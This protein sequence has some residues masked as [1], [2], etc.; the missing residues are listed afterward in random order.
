MESYD[1]A[2]QATDDYII[3][4]M[5]FLC[6]IPKATNTHLEH[7]LPV[8][9][10]G[11]NDF[12]KAPQWY[13]YLYSVCHVEQLMSANDTFKFSHLIPLLDVFAY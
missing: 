3:C 9:F 1:T 6:W 11:N 12:S 2:G 5:R 8:A 7:E 13:V 10:H 4:S